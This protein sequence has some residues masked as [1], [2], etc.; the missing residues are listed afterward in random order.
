M[1]PS[2]RKILRVTLVLTHLFDFPAEGLR[3][4]I[5][6]GTFLHEG[7]DQRRGVLVKEVIT[8]RV[9]LGVTHETFDGRTWNMTQTNSI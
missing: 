2:P 4:I 3:L 6:D 7:V 9:Q 1:S 8:R 5:L